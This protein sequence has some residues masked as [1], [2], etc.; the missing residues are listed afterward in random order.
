MPVIALVGNKGG[1]GKTTLSVNLAAGLAKQAS[2]IV[3]DA[4][5]QGSAKQWNAFTDARTAIPVLEARSNSGNNAGDDLT[6]QL[7]ALSND[8]DY[9]VVDCPPS[10]N[11]SQTITVL[12]ICDLALIPVQ[13]SP[14]DLWATVHTEKA[15]EDAQ[16]SNKNLRAVLVINQ[17]ESRTTLSRLVRDALSEIGLPVAKTAL[18]RRAIFRN[19]ALEG[20]HVF[21]M[22]RRGSD[23]AKEID[24]LIHEVIKI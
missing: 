20:K 14:V 13:P 1:A 6:M 3:V 21:E 10:V 4:D 19:C 22:G 23:A 16:R 8:Y 2:V 17:L 24:Q 11:A 12:Q 9:V 15:V 7:K 18:H 5:P